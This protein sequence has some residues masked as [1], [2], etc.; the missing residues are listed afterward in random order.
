MTQTSLKSVTLREHEVLNALKNNGGQFRRVVKPQ[1]LDDIDLLYGNDIRGSAPHVIDHPET[2]LPWG[3]GFIDEDSKRY[4]C[5]YGQPGDR[6]CV[7]ETWA[8]PVDH[9]PETVIY[10]AGYPSSVLDGYE[11]IPDENDI[12]WKSSALMHKSSSRLPLEITAVRLER[13]QEIMC[14]DA[15]DE[16]FEG[17][18]LCTDGR[19][20]CSVG[21][22]HPFTKDFN[23]H[24]KPGFGFEANPWVWVYEYKVVEQGGEG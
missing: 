6:V 19:G 15:R 9:E 13:V 8:C 11:N 4:L 21:G 18:P 7:R 24:A 17:C 16:G 1:P 3:Y 20:T 12:D 22:L 10:R 14:L 5:P 2:D 23:S